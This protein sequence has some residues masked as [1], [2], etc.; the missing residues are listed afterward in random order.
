M[1]DNQS[2]YQLVSKCPISHSIKIPTGIDSNNYIAI[3]HNWPSNK[4][5]SIYKYNIDNDKWIKMDSFD[6][7]K[8]I[9]TFSAATLDVKRRILFLSQSKSVTQ[10]ELKNNNPIINDI[11]NTRII[12]TAPI[13]INNSLFIVGGFDSNSIWKWNLENKTFTKFSDTYNKIKID[14]FGIINS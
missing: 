12:T 7:V 5:D 13:I 8:N 3:D 6:N 11:H 10:I 9:A 4:I 2:E 14:A 1:S